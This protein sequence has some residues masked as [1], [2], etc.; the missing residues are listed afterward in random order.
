MAAKLRRMEAGYRPEEIAEAEAETARLQAV[1]DQLLVG[2]RSEDLR[3]AEARAA[4]LRG[5]RP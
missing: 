2:T 3:R 4:E 5:A 1:Y